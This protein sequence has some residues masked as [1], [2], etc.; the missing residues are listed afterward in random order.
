M[1]TDEEIQVLNAIGKRIKAFR[2]EKG[3][4]QF[5]LASEAELPKNQ[6]GR[7]ER[8]EINTTILTL[9]KIARALEVDTTFLIAQELDKNN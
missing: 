5:E 3:L 1:Y 2:L 6:V 9:H 4:S 7:I 8:A